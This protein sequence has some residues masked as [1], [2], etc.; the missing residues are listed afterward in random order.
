MFIYRISNMYAHHI[1]IYIYAN[2]LQMYIFLY[3]FFVL[4]K[5]SSI[6]GGLSNLQLHEVV[7]LNSSQLT[8][9]NQEMNQTPSCCCHF[10]VSCRLKPA[11]FELGLSFA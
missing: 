9:Q 5:N 1:Y 6:F 8:A 11:I 4:F 7:I 3:T 10:A 2:E